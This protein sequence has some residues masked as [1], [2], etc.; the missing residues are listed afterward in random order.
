[1]SDTAYKDALADKSGPM[2]GELL[3]AQDGFQVQGTTIVP[4]EAVDIMSHVNDFVN[5]GV[6]LIL[7][8]GGTG[9][10]VRDRTPEVCVYDILI[11]KCILA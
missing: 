4:D 3:S 1:M 5:S 8:T 7:T 9:F 10:G 11:Q 2:I 6:D